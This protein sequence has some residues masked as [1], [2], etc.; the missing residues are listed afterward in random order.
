MLSL[1]PKNPTSV[2]KRS[3]T[4]PKKNSRHQQPPNQDQIEKK[5]TRMAHDLACQQVT[6]RQQQQPGPTKNLFFLPL[7]P[8]DEKAGSIKSISIEKKAQNEYAQSI[9]KVSHFWESARALSYSFLEIK[10]R[11]QSKWRRK[12]HT[13][14]FRAQRA[15]KNVWILDAIIRIE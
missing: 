7:H 12:T 3:I 2:D 4:S 8:D 6:C 10:L 9:R 13:Y 15:Q 1:R 14:K 5:K 11:C